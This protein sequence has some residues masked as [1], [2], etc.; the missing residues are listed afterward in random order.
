MKIDIEGFEP[1]AFLNAKRLFDALDFRLIYMEWLHAKQKDA[2]VVQKMVDFLVSRR[3]TAL[4]GNNPLDLQKWQQW[5]LDICW[6]RDWKH[7]G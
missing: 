2:S 6:I 3:F 7:N 4:S 5:P 1:Y